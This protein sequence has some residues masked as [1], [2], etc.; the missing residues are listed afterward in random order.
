MSKH[1]D[2]LAKLETA[3]L[4][5]WQTVSTTVSESSGHQITL[6]DQKLGLTKTTDLYGEVTAALAV[7]QFAFSNIPESKQVVIFG[8]ETL[9]SL[10]SL[11]R[12]DDVETV[13][14]DVIADLRP[15]FEAIVQG[16]C[17]A[18]GT[19]H[20]EPVVATGLMIRFQN[21]TF[22]RN[23]QKSDELFRCEVGVRATGVEGNIVWLFDVESASAITGLHASGLEPTAEEVERL[24]LEAGGRPELSLGDSVPGLDILMDIPLEISVELGRSKMLVRD[25]LDLGTGSIVELNKIAGEPIDVLVNGRLVAHGEVVVIED[26][27]GVRVTE[28]LSPFERLQK[29]N[30][31]A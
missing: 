5:I 7:V 24:A 17:V 2:L 25:V 26:N 13:D 19:M 21:F 31:A 6:G 16:I 10:G 14:D 30:E 20:S 28:I 29:L 22:P 1:S 27:F 15:V 18:M 9:A 11:V 12:N 4:Q 23:F 8:Q 3:Q